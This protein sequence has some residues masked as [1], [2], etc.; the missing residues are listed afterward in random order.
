VDLKI[1][2]H[3]IL[4]KRDPQAANYTLFRVGNVLHVMKNLVFDADGA[5]HDMAQRLDQ[6]QCQNMLKLYQF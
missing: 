1:V 4:V 2:D 3:P 6:H 5:G